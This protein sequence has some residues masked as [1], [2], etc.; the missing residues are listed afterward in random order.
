MLGLITALAGI[1][2]K[3][4]TATGIGLTA[5]ARNSSTSEFV[6]IKSVKSFPRRHV[7]K[8]SQ[9]LDH[10]QVYAEGADYDFVLEYIAS[11]CPKAKIAK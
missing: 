6:H 10:N 2:S 9:G 11:H 8:I 4:L 3:S 7:I 5:A 1:A